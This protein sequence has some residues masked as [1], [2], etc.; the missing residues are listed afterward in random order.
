MNEVLKLRRARQ[1]SKIIFIDPKVKL[2]V[3][4][5]KADGFPT[6]ADLVTPIEGEFGAADVFDQLAKLK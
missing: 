2:I 1:Q 4:R 6:L 5:I 3:E